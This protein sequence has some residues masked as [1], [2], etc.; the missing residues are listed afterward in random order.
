MEELSTIEPSATR[1]DLDRLLGYK[2]SVSMQDLALTKADVTKRIREAKKE[3]HDDGAAY[4]WSTF[5]VGT[6]INI[7]NDERGKVIIS[8]LDNHLLLSQAIIFG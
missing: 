4:V 1:L 5:R 3:F 7:I 2:F 6:V 8:H